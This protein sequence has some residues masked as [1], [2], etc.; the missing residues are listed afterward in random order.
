[1][2]SNEI[3]KNYLNTFN[4]RTVLENR[5]ENLIER[6]KNKKTTMNNETIQQTID[7]GYKRLEELKKSEEKLHTEYMIQVQK[8][9]EKNFADI[10]IQHNL[11]KKSTMKYI[12]KFVKQNYLQII[13]SSF[14]IISK[15]SSYQSVWW[16]RGELNPCPK[17]KLY[18]Y[19]QV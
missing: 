6:W 3:Y 15:S 10:S 18:K 12:D 19:L 7:K 11:E 9:K 2:N 17:A 13:E 5:I 8:E 4:E 1:M 14:Y 16:R